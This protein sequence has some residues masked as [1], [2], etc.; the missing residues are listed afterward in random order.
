LAKPI[1]FGKFKFGTRKSCEEEARSRI[2]SYTAGSVL[3][4]IDKCFFEALFTLHSEYDEKVGCGIRHIEVSLDFH[5]NKCLA[6]IRNDDSREIISWRHCIKP[7]T[8]KMVVSYSFR[9]AIKNTITEFK[10]QAISDGSICPILSIKLTFGNSHV[11]YIGPSFDDLLSNF[12]EENSLNYESVELKDPE[13]E[14][15]DQRGILFDPNITSNWRSYINNHAE[16][17]LLSAD[18]NLRK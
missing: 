13:A 8:Q 17:A 18:A 1:S 15:S 12:L 7:H 10:R 6:I 11:S 16:L 3:S 4:V 5:N 2:N 14:D 9:R